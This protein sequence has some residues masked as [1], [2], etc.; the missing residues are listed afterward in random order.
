ML[1][2]ECSPPNGTISFKTLSDLTTFP[3]C[4]NQS[5]KSWRWLVVA[6][7]RRHSSPLREGPGPADLPCR[8]GRGNHIHRT[9]CVCVY[10]NIHQLLVS[11]VDALPWQRLVQH[12]LTWVL[13]A[14]L[15]W[16]QMEDGGSPFAGQ[17]ISKMC[18]IKYDTLRTRALCVETLLWFKLRFVYRRDAC[19]LPA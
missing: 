3:H 15:S 2:T 6:A 12:S 16:L 17:T 14:L 10:D 7:Q 1:T 8:P 18:Q 9:V 5:V 11:W 13:Q 4:V 19:C